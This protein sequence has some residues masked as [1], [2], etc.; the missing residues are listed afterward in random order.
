MSVA[1]LSLRLL[2]PG[3]VGHIYFLGT[4]SKSLKKL[5]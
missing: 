4:A 5:A 3:W 2:Q 1:Y